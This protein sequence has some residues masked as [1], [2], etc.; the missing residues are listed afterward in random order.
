MKIKFWGCRGSIPVPDTRMM[1]YGGDTPCVEVILDGT[2]FIIDAGTGI[3]KLGEDLI[4]RKIFDMDIFITHSHWDHIQGFPF[5]APIYSEKTKINIFGYGNSYKGLKDIFTS[6]M[7]SEYF[8]IAFSNLKSKI[9][10]IESRSHE[11]KIDGYIIKTIR[12][13]HPIYTLGIRIEKN[14]KSFV[15]MTDNELGLDKPK[16]SENEFIEFCKNATYLIHD[17]Q[18]TEDEYKERNGWGH[19]TYEQVINFAEKAGVENVGF[20]HHDPNRQDNE[21]ARMERDLKKFCKN[22]RCK[23][24]VFAVKELEEIELK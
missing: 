18:F 4:K 23:F 8:P 7:S 5:F 1:R 21:L 17:A 22:R 16:T 14:D 2:V 24:H 13:N 10:F 6:Q 15:F 20:F 11:Y 19:S 9:D 3:R 12:T